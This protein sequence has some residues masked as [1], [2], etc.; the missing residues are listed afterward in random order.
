MINSIKAPF[1][2]LER[3]LQESEKE[4]TKHDTL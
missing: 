1:G 4:E 2:Y 3:Y